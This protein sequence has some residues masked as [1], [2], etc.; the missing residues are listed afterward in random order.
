[1]PAQVVEIL[2]WEGCEQARI[3]RDGCIVIVR[4]F[5][6]DPKRRSRVVFQSGTADYDFYKTRHHLN[7]PGSIGRIFQGWLK[8]KWV[9]YR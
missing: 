2:E 7:K 6:T 3:R 8:D 4:W 1:M 9:D 5:R